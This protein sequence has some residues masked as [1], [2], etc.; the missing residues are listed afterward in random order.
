MNLQQNST[1]KKKVKNLIIDIGNTRTKLAIYKNKNQ[2]D[3]QAF[4]NKNQEEILFFLEQCN[5]TNCIITATGKMNAT[6]QNKLYK[7]FNCIEINEFIK[8]PFTIQYKTKNTL[9]DDRI[10]A[11]SGAKLL[12]PNKNC[13]AITAG[14]CLTFNFLTKENQFLG[15]SISP[16]LMMRLK[17]MNAFTDK[18]PL[19]T[20]TD[21]DKLIGTTTNESLLSGARKGIVAE[22]D[23]IIDQYRLQF[24]EIEVIICGGDTSFFERRLKNKIFAHQNLVLDGMNEILQYNLKNK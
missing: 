12:F 20:N 8:L 16:G 10:A 6:I 17:A 18:L 2:I 11:I 1:I 9:G 14:T 7:T 21:F 15:G 19:P 22:V 3:F 13:L 5:A 23:G 24:Q 4:L